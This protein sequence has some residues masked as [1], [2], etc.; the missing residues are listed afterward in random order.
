M[1]SAN[2]LTAVSQFVNQEASQDYH[3][4]I[5]VDKIKTFYEAVIPQILF[6][7]H[8]RH[9]ADVSIQSEVQ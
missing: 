6:T 1:T 4:C 3:H 5:A 8:F 9:L 2:G 7:L